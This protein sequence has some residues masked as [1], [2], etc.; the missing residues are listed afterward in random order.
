MVLFLLC[1]A[2]L[3]L[4]YLFSRAGFEPRTLLRVVRDF[5]SLYMSCGL[6]KSPVLLKTHRPGCCP[7]L[8]PPGLKT[9]SAFLKLK[10]TR[11]RV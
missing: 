10:S 1:F 9:V 4:V 7:R 11:L 6:A 3:P 2:I 8:S 5:Q